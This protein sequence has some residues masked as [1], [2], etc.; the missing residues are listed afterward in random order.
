MLMEAF[1]Q[2]GYKGKELREL[3]KCKLYLQCANL[4]DITNGKGNKI[5]AAAIRCRHQSALIERKQYE[6][7]TQP[8]PNQLQKLL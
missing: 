2:N 4:A 7:P 3:N 6:W 1:M 8:A 5:L